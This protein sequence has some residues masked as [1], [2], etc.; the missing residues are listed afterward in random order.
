MYIGGLI[1]KPI[2]APDFAREY[3]RSNLLKPVLSPA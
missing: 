1:L 2:L 3:P